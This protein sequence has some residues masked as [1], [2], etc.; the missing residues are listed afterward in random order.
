MTAVMSKIPLVTVK[1]VIV[2][3][4]EP[5]LAP[6]AEVISKI[7][8]AMTSWTIKNPIAILP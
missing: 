2:K 4:L 1:T 6:T 3:R 5:E 7:S 8:V